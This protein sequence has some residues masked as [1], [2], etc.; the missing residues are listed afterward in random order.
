[1]I[2]RHTCEIPRHCDPIFG[3]NKKKSLRQKRVCNNN[4]SVLYFSLHSKIDKIRRTYPE[5]TN[6]LTKKWTA[7]NKTFGIGHS[8]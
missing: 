4:P 8:L 1:M 6:T 5:N 2:F 7:K 3:I